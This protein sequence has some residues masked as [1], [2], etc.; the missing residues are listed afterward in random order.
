[1]TRLI[2]IPVGLVALAFLIFSIVDIA[3]TDKR[4]VRALNKFVWFLVVLL[5]IIGP[6]L[7]FFFGRGRNSGTSERRMVAPD[8]D[9]NFLKKIGTNE[10]QNE[11]IRRLEQELSEL[12]DDNP[13]K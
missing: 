11:R 6:V 8:D 4:Q 10:D 2:V 1:M 5:P 7:W 9:L 12:D 13:P 3:M